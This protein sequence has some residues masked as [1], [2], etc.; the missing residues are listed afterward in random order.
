LRVEDYGKVAATFV[1]TTGGAAIRIAPQPSARQLAASYAP[2]AGNI[3]EAMLI[4]YQRMAPA[5]LFVWRPV[6]LVTPVAAIISRAGQRARCERCGE[7]IFNERE[8]EVNGRTFCRHCAHSGYYHV[9]TG[10]APAADEL[11]MLAA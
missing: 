11:H 9:G 8:V 10:A 5:E 7:E 6:Q 2:E 3:W 4:G 1:N